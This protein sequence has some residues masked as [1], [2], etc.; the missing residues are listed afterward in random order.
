MELYETAGGDERTLLQLRHELENRSAKRATELLSKIEQDLKPQSE[1]SYDPT[2]PPHLSTRS[3][4]SAR[5]FTRLKPILVR[6]KEAAAG[7]SVVE[8]EVEEEGNFTTVS[9]QRFALNQAKWFIDCWAH[10]FNGIRRYPLTE[11]YRISDSEE[12]F[13]AV[14]RELLASA[15]T[16]SEEEEWKFVAQGEL[17][18][19]D[20]WLTDSDGKKIIVD[21]TDQGKVKGLKLPAG[22][23]QSP[24]HENPDRLSPTT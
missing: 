15:F 20:E 18:L 24:Q 11:V 16:A 22:E 8:L 3:V 10:E 6:L 23:S 14:P 4:L 7:L 1:T 21:E 17:D 12:A 5:Q 2:V 19:I 13:I 9:I